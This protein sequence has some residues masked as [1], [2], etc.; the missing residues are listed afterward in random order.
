M[1]CSKVQVIAVVVKL[2]ENVPLPSGIADRA[3]L[4]GHSHG[5]GAGGEGAGCWARGLDD[6]LAEHGELWF[7]VLR[8][9]GVLY[10]GIG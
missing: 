3:S 2:R 6:G 10:G 7:A 5:A 9:N 1:P 8:G 4:A